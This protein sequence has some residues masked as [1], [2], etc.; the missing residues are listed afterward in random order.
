MLTVNSSIIWSDFADNAYVAFN[1]FS[2]LLTRGVAKPHINF[3]PN[4]GVLTQRHFQAEMTASATS[5]VYTF[6]ALG[7]PNGMANGS[8]NAQIG[9]I[10]SLDV[11]NAWAEVTQT[12]ITIYIT[13]NPYAVNVSYSIA[14]TAF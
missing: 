8:W 3:G 13:S 5:T 9:P 4:T 2:G 11:G 14:L 12:G 1:K 10:A 6:A 7:L